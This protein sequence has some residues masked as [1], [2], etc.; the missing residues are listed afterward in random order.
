MDAERWRQIEELYHSALDSDV[1][2]R[3]K[4]LAHADPDVRREVESLLAQ[5]AADTPLDRSAFSVLNRPHLT[6]GALIGPYRIEGLL[7]EGGMGVVYRAFDPKLKRPVAV[8]LLP[9]LADAAARQRF[10]REARTVTALNH[11]HILTVYDVGELDGRQYLVTELVDGGT[12][13]SWAAAEKRS[14]RQIVDV[15][16][17]VADGLATAHEAGIIHRDVK[18]E[19]ILI[20]KNG[21]AKLADF[22]LAKLFQPDAAQTST[23]VAPTRH[24]MIAGT[25]GYMSPE[26]ASGNIVDA[27]SDIFSFGAVLYE[28]F[29]GQRPF[30][31]KSDLEELQR[32]IHGTP[33][34]LGGPTPL[35]LRMV[36]EKALEKDPADRY[37][38]TR[39]LVIDLR[40]ASRQSGSGYAAETRS[41]NEIN[42]G[43]RP[44]E[45]TSAPGSYQTRQSRLSWRAAAVWF[46]GGVGLATAVTLWRVQPPQTPATFGPIRFQIPPGVRLTPSSPFSV[47]PDGRHLV[48]AGAGDDSIVRLWVRS[49]DALAV[50]PLSGTEVALGGLT[51]PMFWSPDSRFVAF[52]A[53]G[54]LKKVDVR[55]G[56]PQKVCDLPV[57]AVGGAWN[58]NDVI[59][60]GSPKGG[61]MRCPASGGTASVVTQLD[62]SRG[63]SGHVFP[64]FL[65]DGRHFLY[66]RVSRNAP[67][68]SGVYLRA[69]ETGSGDSAD[70]RILAT[71]FGAAYVPGAVSGVGRILF[72]RDAALYAQPFDERRLEL[73]GNAIRV[74]E[75]IGSFLDGAFFSAST[76]GVLVFRG[77]DEDRQLT[78]FDRRGNILGR[79]SEPGR[80]RGLTLDPSG[81]RALVVR[82]ADGATVDQDLWLVELS[83]SRASKVTF[84]SRLEDFP[85]W[86]HDGKKLFFTAGGGIGPLFEQSLGGT[87]A[88]Q[89]LLQT[90]EHLIPT[91][92]SP[93]GHFLLYCAV[94]IGETRVDLWVL[95]LQGDRKPFPFLRRAFDQCQGQFSPD[96]RWV[97]YVSN[98]SGR[99]EVLVRPFTPSG[100]AGAVESTVVSQGG[101]IAPRWRADGKALFYLGANGTLSSVA[102]TTDR[103]LAIGPPRVLFQV[104]GAD[105]AWAVTKD[106]ERF[107]L[108]APSL[109][110]APSPFT[111]VFNWQAASNH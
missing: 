104:P 86:S 56:A 49:M 92:A 81:T 29:A 58:R 80:Y 111:V 52:D 54:Q 12:L 11:P 62:S 45:I 18:P 65:P 101:G 68:N 95:P 55:G 9:D 51:P 47:S 66:L 78:W 84:D 34:P 39:E 73:S 24:G 53:A 37:Q 72:V 109:H 110:S 61:L 40:R 85:V 91:N 8:K 90:E 7:G 5:P 99:Y 97:A 77:P 102:L 93:D 76:S 6:I 17:G 70:R 28:L 64:S 89:V 59:I 25:V 14:W 31:G 30:S 21:Y 20:A 16:V 57:L 2:E 106:G 43:A 4:L 13:R 15:L 94:S 1:A 63:E 50:Q 71:P 103:A 26:Q 23:R 67:E 107:L 100:A 74:A 19:N 60:V 69:L 46:I 27:R 105:A 82:R 75:P 22:G 3:A 44:L 83:G 35:P 96:G 48:F 41:P 38:T 87:D 88:A 108:A 33:E 79:A 98:E 32:I 36:I 42:D 10:Q